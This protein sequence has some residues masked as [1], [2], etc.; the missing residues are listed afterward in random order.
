MCSAGMKA[1]GILSAP[2]P[3]K[4]PERTVFFEAL[5]F[6]FAWLLNFGPK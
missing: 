5:Y 3:Q 4:V 1:Q 6:A 2:E